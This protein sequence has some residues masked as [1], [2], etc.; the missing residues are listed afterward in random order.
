MRPDQHLLREEAREQIKR[1]LQAIDDPEAVLFWGALQKASNAWNDV[2]GESD[3]P[4]D[5]LKE[6]IASIDNRLREHILAYLHPA[7]NQ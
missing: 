1:A 7:A 2:Q 4:A 5:E 3:R 6:D